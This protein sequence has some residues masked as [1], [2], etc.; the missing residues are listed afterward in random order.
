MR[1]TSVFK[2]VSSCRYHSLSLERYALCV[3]THLKPRQ[4]QDNLRV[5][6]LET[7]AHSLSVEMLFDDALRR[8]Y[9]PLL[10]DLD[11]N[12]SSIVAFQFALAF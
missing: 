2:A 6:V 9:L 7:R 10:A 11:Q 12:T 1:T 3:T 5:Q 4:R 8:I